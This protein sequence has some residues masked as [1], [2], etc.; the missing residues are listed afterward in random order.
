MSL[1]IKHLFI[2]YKIIFIIIGFLF[3]LR[4]S[5]YIL[6]FVYNLGKY[7]GNFMRNIYE[8]VTTFL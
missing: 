4:F 2:K 5:N 1:K 3:F 8:I 7:F 6:L